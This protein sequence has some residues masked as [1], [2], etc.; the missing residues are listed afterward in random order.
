MYK[1]QETIKYKLA[2]IEGERASVIRRIEAQVRETYAGKWTCLMNIECP[3]AKIQM[4]GSMA[5]GLAIDSSDMDLLISG[6]F[7]ANMK[8]VDIPGLNFNKYVDRHMLVEYMRRFYSTL[9]L[10]K[11]V[12]ES[13]RKGTLRD[14]IE[15]SQIIE[16]AS[17]PVIKLV[18]LHSINF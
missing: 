10:P 3:N 16:T 18:I 11:P 2:C 15:S 9:S 8:V 7:N 6:I 5:T 13:Q 14:F 12:E 4:Y 17:V 1:L